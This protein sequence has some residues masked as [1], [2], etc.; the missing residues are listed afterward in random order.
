MIL[1]KKFKYN[2]DIQTS[3]AFQDIDFYVQLSRLFA[4][5][6]FVS[7]IDALALVHYKSIFATDK[8]NEF[9]PE[10]LKVLKN[11][12]TTRGKDSKLREYL[13]KTL[14]TDLVEVKPETLFDDINNHLEYFP[15]VNQRVFQIGG[16]TNQD[17]NNQGLK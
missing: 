1:D 2:K 3:F 4:S 6:M 10:I 12:F 17:E 11:I 9:W 7:D 13:L 8:Y 15:M 16:N 5:K 14:D